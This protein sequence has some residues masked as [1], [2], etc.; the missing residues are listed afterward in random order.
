VAGRT[1][2]T[3]GV[4]A[5]IVTAT[6]VATAAGHASVGAAPTVAE[7]AELQLKSPAFQKS[8]LAATVFC[9]R[10]TSIRSTASL[11]WT[12]CP[13]T[14]IA[15]PC[16]EGVVSVSFRSTPLGAAGE[17]DSLGG[18]NFP[19]AGIFALRGTGVYRC[20]ASDIDRQAGRTVI[21]SYAKTLPLRDQAVGFAAVGEKV[22]VTTSIHPGF[23]GPFGENASVRLGQPDTCQLAGLPIGTQPVRASW[24][25]TTF[26]PAALTSISTRITSSGTI[27]RSL[28]VSRSEGLSPGVKIEGQV[29]WSSTVVVVPALKRG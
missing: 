3:I 1:K 12:T 15:E 5:T 18:E 4:V 25:G 26:K 22:K 9:L 11:S 2:A 17:P 19:G 21:R 7:C 6:A 28:P 14:P 13:T 8:R 10:P 20:K 29:K 23:R 24:P 27:P 16:A